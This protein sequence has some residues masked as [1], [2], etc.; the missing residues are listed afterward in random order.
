MLSFFKQQNIFRCISFCIFIILS[1]ILFIK[2]NKYYNQNNFAKIILLFILTCNF[3]IGSFYLNFFKKN[4]IFAFYFFLILYSINSLLVI[5]DLINLPENQIKKIN[6]RMG[7]S[8]DHR[9]LIE[10]ISEERKKGNNIFPYVVPRE[11]ISKN[12]SNK[13]IL[14]PITNQ[15]YVS[16]NEYGFWKKIK[17]DRMGFNNKIALSNFDI[18][19]VGDSFAEGS[20]VHQNNEP[21][22]LF[23]NKYN[24]E[25]YNIGISGNGPLINLALLHELNNKFNFKKIVWF[26]YDNDFYDLKVEYQNIQLKEYL[27]KNFKKNNYFL[28]LKDTNKYQKKYIEENLKSFKKRY[29][30]KENLFEL[31][32]L[33][34]RLNRILNFKKNQKNNYLIE[35]ELLIQIFEKVK[36]LYDNKEIY[37]VYIPET[38]CFKSRK[39][40][41]EKRAMILKNLVKKKNFINFYET[42]KNGS[43]EYK[44]YYALGIDNFHLS[45]YGYQ[46]LVDTVHK[47]IN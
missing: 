38:S 4:I 8:F 20:C 2:F 47:K 22:N 39:I 43:Q 17:T 10:V 24:I 42:I 28:K 6:Q 41:C 1:T 32:P 36:T 13:I 26:F 34:H 16:C 46:Y 14:T 5:F 37:L 29:S 19:L 25:T 23:K 7:K 18:L 30:I 27:S 21:A 33:L 40:D 3:L 44:K 31:K 45:N 11:F 15:N 35:K 9:N 12:I